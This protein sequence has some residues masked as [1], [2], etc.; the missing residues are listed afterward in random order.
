MKKIIAQKKWVYTLY[1]TESGVIL[2]VICGGAAMFNVDVQLSED[3]AKRIEQD[4]KYL[5]ALAEKVRADPK[6]Y[7]SKLD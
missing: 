6:Q 5:E 1:E 7:I 2:S 4:E 3:E